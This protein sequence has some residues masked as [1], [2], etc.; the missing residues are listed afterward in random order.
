MHPSLSSGGISD[1][2]LTGTV[3][4]I[5]L[6]EDHVAQVLKSNHPHPQGQGKPVEGGGDRV[7]GGASFRSDFLFD[8]DKRK[9]G[10]CAPV[11]AGR[12]AFR[13]QSRVQ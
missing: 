5:M 2:V 11:A 12:G 10:S 7:H 4:P 1:R 3:I 13:H 8:A 9:N 6:V